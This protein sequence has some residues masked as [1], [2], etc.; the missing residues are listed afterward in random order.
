MVASSTRTV[1]AAKQNLKVAEEPEYFSTL[2]PLPNLHIVLALFKGA[3]QIRV[4]Y[5]LE[6]KSQLQN[7]V[8]TE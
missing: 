1:L 2:F 4:L 8:F 7:V 5:V 3:L 6:I